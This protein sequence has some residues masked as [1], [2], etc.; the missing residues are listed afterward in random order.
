MRSWRSAAAE[1]LGPAGGLLPDERVHEGLAR[2]GSRAGWRRAQAE[3]LGDSRAWVFP[4]PLRWLAWVVVRCRWWPVPT[5]L[6]WVLRGRALADAPVGLCWALAVLSGSPLVCGLAAFFCLGL[7]EGSLALVP[8]LVVAA[9]WAGVPWVAAGVAAW[10]AVTTVVC[11]RAWVRV[12]LKSVL[13]QGHGYTR[14]FQSGGVVRV[15]VDAL[16][17]SGWV[18]LAAAWLQ[19]GG[20]AVW[21][22][23]VALVAQGLGPVQNVRVSVGPDLVMR[24]VVASAL[25]SGQGWRGLVVLALGTG[26]DAWT[27]W[28][29]RMVRDPVTSEL[30]AA[31]GRRG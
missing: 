28:R 26:V 19:V 13:E 5:P 20:T 9:G 24:W 6:G 8:A 22:A 23:L 10:A 16:M 4:P 18:W 15:C 17:V 21:A 7:K 11:G 1:R 2:L 14:E 27:S 12:L 31:L 3:Y 25:V 29:L 30:G